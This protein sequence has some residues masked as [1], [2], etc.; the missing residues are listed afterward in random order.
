MANKKSGR[1]SQTRT[2]LSFVTDSVVLGAADRYALD[3]LFGL[4]TEV[5][6]IGTANDGILALPRKMRISLLAFGLE[7]FAIKPYLVQTAGTITDTTDS[8]VESIDGLLDAAVDDNFGY[9]PLLKNVQVSKFVPDR[10]GSE[11]DSDWGVLLNFDVPQDMLALLAK[12]S[13]SERLQNLFTVVWLHGSAADTI[14]LRAWL[15][16]EFVQHRKGIIHR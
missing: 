14:Y 15:E 7:P 10:N 3:A 2:V 13:D 9:R 5:E 11:A 12:E 16:V 6:A 4:H 8:T 1:K